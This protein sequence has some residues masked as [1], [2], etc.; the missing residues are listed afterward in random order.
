[1]HDTVSRTCSGLPTLNNTATA[2]SSSFRSSSSV[3][4]N[5]AFGPYASYRKPYFR[6]LSSLPG[7]NK[8]RRRT[9][10]RYSVASGSPSTYTT[11]MAKP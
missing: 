4:Q 2:V 9:N 5:H 1:M 8:A 11:I 7:P 10:S 6:M 3:S